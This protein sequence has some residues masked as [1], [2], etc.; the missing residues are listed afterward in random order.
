VIVGAE[1]SVRNTATGINRN[2]TTDSAGF[3]TVPN[4]NPGPYE[5]KVTAKGFTTALQSNL[6]LAVGAQQ[7]LNIPMKVGE[8]S[9]TVQVTEAA[10][11]IELTSSTLSGQI[12]SQTV[13]ELPLNG[14]DWA[15]LASLSPGVNALETQMPFE[16]GA[17]RGNRGFGA[18]LTISGGRPTQNNYRLDGLSINDYGNGGPGSVIGGNLGV[19]A[20]QE[21]SVLTGNYSAEYGRTSGGV[22]NAI[23]KSG[24]NAFHGDLYEFLRNEKLDARN[25]FLN[26]SSKFQP[27]PAYKRNQF[28]A[29][30]GGP[31]R[32][33]RTF[34]FFDY[35]GI[36]QVKGV[37][38][39]S[40][41]PS[42]NA[43]KGILADPK[44]PGQY[45]APHTGSCPANSS[46]LDPAANVCVDNRVMA[47]ANRPS[48]L[49]G[50]PP[51]GYLDLYPDAPPVPF[52]DNGTFTF[53][54]AR[55]V[56]ENYYTLRV[57]HKIGDKD[58]LF[59]TYM[60]DKTP[61]TQ[62]DAFNNITVFSQTG[63]DI[64]ALE[65]T[66]VFS[67]TLV[68]TARVGYNRN[69]VLN[70]FTTGA[71]NPAAKDLSLGSLPGTYSP[72]IRL[73]APFANPLA[74]LNGSGTPLTWNSIQFYDDA[75]LTRGTHAL[76]FGFAL[77]RMQYDYLTVYNPNGIWRFKGLAKFLTNQPNSLEAGGLLGRTR[78][79]DLRQTLFGGY[80]QDDWRLRRNLTLNLGLRY[81]MTT[82]V[83]ER[84]GRIA[85]LRNISDPLP[86]CGTSD[87][88]LTVII[89]TPNP[90]GTPGCS[91][92]TAPYYSNPTKLNFE[93]RFGFSWDPRGDGKTA[94]RGGAAIFDVLPLPG[95][96]FSQQGIEMPYYLTALLAT[97]TVP[98]N[99]LLGVPASDPKSAYQQMLQSPSSFTGGI[100]ESNPKRNYVEQWNI[101]VQRQITPNLTATV[102]Y[103]GS[104]GVHQL[105]RGDDA[106]MVIPTLTSAGYLWPTPGT[107]VRVNTHFGGLRYLFWGTGSSYKSLQASV[108]KR[109]SHGFQFGGSYTYSKG[110][111]DDSA[112]L[113]G[114]AFSNSVTSWFWFA[115]QISHAVSD[116]NITHSTAI[117][118]IWNVPGPRAGF[119]QAVLGGWELGSILKVNSGV[120]TTPLIGG[121]PLGVGNIGSDEMSIPDRV[122]GCDPVNHNFKSGPGGIP[123]G[124]INYACFTLPKA[125]SDP[126]LASQCQTF[127][128]VPHDP[129]KTPDPF[130]PGIAGTCANLLGNAGRN[131]VVG[132]GLVN[133]DFSVFKNIAVKK[134][135]ESA[136][137]QF[138]AEFFNIM[139]HANFAPPFPF[140]GSSSS[141]LFN[142]NG[143]S[144]KAGFLETTVTDAR[145]IQFGLKLIW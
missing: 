70:F 60:Y 119:A 40:T 10:P 142:E 118:A 51:F 25:F 61:Y 117:N 38:V 90:A 99:G 125:P 84:T 9:Q 31:I 64:A 76:K 73:G 80:I 66:H 32:K 27:T 7:Q 89:T 63:R 11:Q 30:I 13:L 110:M 39:S 108:Q 103:V 134:I 129:S 19:D 140:F 44:N 115:P 42:E 127:G 71:T 107:G 1:I 5:V 18:Q 137:V 56:T 83:N 68:N 6:T 87:P 133:L 8:T 105:I 120:P 46:L 128:F 106:D 82:V 77:E 91:P 53:S 17:V 16:A 136:S 58:N 29:A 122:P 104:R 95:Y 113:L 138:R 33:D 141:T 23:S 132:P 145:D 112:T 94:V 57:D 41:V 37:T 21:F 26:S 24:S 14:R 52:S 143:T 72:N 130:N 97:K 139:N 79:H 28:G 75:F 98:L 59:A 15:S 20:I 93:P 85:N 144:A 69:A 114:D 81:E 55:V 48:G 47:V 109:M 88:A 100:T 62:P 3:Y 78:P 126:A 45:L 43:R 135:S 116:F 49:S 65:E 96:F 4:L 34:F 74:G 35:E 86:Y 131:S 12:E 121:D 111:D 92:G 2:T 124:Y 102:G 36:R 67:P 22:V 50:L 54:G 123:L 101:N